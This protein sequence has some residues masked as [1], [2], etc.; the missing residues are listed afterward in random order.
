MPSKEHIDRIKKAL[1]KNWK[2]ITQISREAGVHY[3]QTGVI[4]DSLLK[5]KEVDFDEKPGA[6]YWRKKK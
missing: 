6:R 1:T 3:Y 5:E 2:S 4:L